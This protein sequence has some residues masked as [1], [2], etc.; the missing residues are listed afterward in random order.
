M[1]P[2]AR[3]HASR[4]RA[5]RLSARTT[6]SRG[7]ALSAALICT[8]LM[9]A[10]LTSASV[11]D[12]ASNSHLKVT[13]APDRPGARTTIKVSLTFGATTEGNPLTGLDLRLP[14]GVGLVTST[15]GQSNCQAARLVAQG[16]SGCS[17]NARIGHGTATAVINVGAQPVTEHATLDALMGPAAEDRIEVLFF[18]QAEEPVAARLVLPSVVQEFPPPFGEGLETTIPLVQ[19]WP[20]G[21]DLALRT[22][23]STIGPL[24]LTYYHR[25][26]GRSVSYKPSGIRLPQSC[27]NGGYRFAARLHF[28]D[29]TETE[30]GYSVPC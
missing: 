1:S 27:P 3:Q 12:T 11:A 15:L 6:T 29:G 7:V 22:F 9:C 28:G 26:G 13:L 17:A 16:L 14:A 25:V 21:P 30:V 5:P 8:T 4:F 24:G 2:A 10:C 20:E 19:T 23:G 18:V